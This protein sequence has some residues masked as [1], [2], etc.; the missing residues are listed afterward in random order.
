MPGI[1]IHNRSEAILER[2]RVE[3]NEM[4]AIAVGENSKALITDC[5]LFDNLQ[6]GMVSGIARRDRGPLHNLALAP[7]WSPHHAGFGTL[8][9][10]L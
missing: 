1:L 2:C 9:K 6:V 8:H 5:E 10:R 3:R 4:A 7:G